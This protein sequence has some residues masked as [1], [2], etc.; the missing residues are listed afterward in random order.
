MKPLILLCLL[1][2][3]AFAG[4]PL[5]HC[6]DLFHPHDDPDDHLDLATVFALP[7]YDLRA[8]LL[9]QGDKQLKKP[10]RIPVEQMIALTGRRVPY[11]IG[12]GAKLRSP[13]D[14]GLEQ[15]QEFQAAVELFLKVLR[16]SSQKVTV[17]AVGSMRDIAAAYNREP[18]LVRQKVEA[19]HISIGNASVNGREY[20][21]D[22]DPQAFRAL[23]ASK[24]PIYWY[25]C[26]PDKNVRSSHWK[27]PHYADVLDDAPLP[28]QSF[29]LYMLHRVDPSEVEPL[30][31]LKMNLRPW[32]QPF[33]SQPKDMWS[34][35]DILFAAGRT[36]DAG[37]YHFEPALVEV[38]EQGL[39]TRLEYK[40]SKSNVQAFVLEDVDQYTKA[41]TAY[42][43]DLFKNFPV[44]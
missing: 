14:K 21:V 23:L 12:L 16:E 41:M 3:A 11:A 17:I 35:V 26:F 5:V 42:V 4:V 18:A 36:R 9:D 39:T 15:P 19:L 6:T 32:R 8:I 7:E 40:S 24:L 22:L 34:T 43:H 27:L 13:N 1:A 31:A 33:W 38:N 10:G 29:F 20:N 2:T 28:L 25:P 37:L 44:K 30:A